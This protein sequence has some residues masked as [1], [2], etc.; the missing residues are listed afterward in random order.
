MLYEVITVAQDCL[1]H[2]QEHKTQNHGKQ[3][4]A[5]GIFHFLCH[6]DYKFNRIT[7]YTVCYTKLLRTA[8]KGVSYYASGGA[9][10]L[11]PDTSSGNEYHYLTATV[12]SD[13]VTVEQIREPWISS[14]SLTRI[15]SYNVC[16]TKLLRLM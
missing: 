14:H 12:T 6:R 3:H 16:Y 4:I 7:S 2:K 10:G 15:T 1:H 11:L 5:F 8:V 13:G 9:G